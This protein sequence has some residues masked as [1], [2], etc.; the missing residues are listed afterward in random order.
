MFRI[1]IEFDL[2]FDVFR[3]QLTSFVHFVFLGYGICLLAEWCWWV[4]A[5]CGCNIFDSFCFL[6]VSVRVCGCNISSK[7][8]FVNG[9]ILLS[10]WCYMLY[11]CKVVEIYVWWFLLM[12]WIGTC[13]L[14]RVRAVD[15][16]DQYIFLG[17]AIYFIW[18]C[19]Q[20]LFLPVV[21]LYPSTFDSREG[22]SLNQMFT[23]QTVLPGIHKS[24]TLNCMLQRGYSNDGL[25]ESS[26]FC[27]C[28][29]RN[30]GVKYAIICNA[31]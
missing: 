24:R 6:V 19:L 12:C 29:R 25:F 13:A 2:L 17:I 4:F 22:P 31:S 3:Q 15:D 30:G 10:L 18:I 23:C 28:D 14:S 1:D 27:R 21:V 16:V 26:T 7:I 9:L 20:I 5:V 11:C 8:V